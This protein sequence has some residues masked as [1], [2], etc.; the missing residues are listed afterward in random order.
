MKR[1]EIG[2]LFGILVQLA[3]QNKSLESWKSCVVRPK[4]WSDVP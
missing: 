1:N 3:Y 4:V 2:I